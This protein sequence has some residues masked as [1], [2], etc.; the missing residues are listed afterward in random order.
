MSDAGL[1]RRTVSIVPRSKYLAAVALAALFLSLLELTDVVD[2]PF[3]AKFS[4][5][6][7]SGGVFSSGLLTSMLG[8]G[9]GGLFALMAME[10]ASL[11]IPSEVVLPW[12]GYL[13]FLGQMNLVLAVADST[14]ALLV[15]SLVAYFLALWLGRPVIYRILGR[16]GVSA[17]HLDDGERWIDSKGAWA[18]FV[19]RFIPGLRS[20]IS[21]PAGLLKMQIRSFA[22]LTFAGSLIWSTALIYVGYSAGSLWQS[23]LGSLYIFADQAALVI[24]AAV[25]VLYVLYYL[26][27]LGR[28][29]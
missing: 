7:A 10:G 25:S 22:I 5:V 3:E 27:P 17:S 23:A 29:K 1:P 21:I 18:V 26:G 20:V 16:M 19:S 8:I 6:V 11:P 2:L 12:A 24:V 15:G 14:M 13:V 9:Y 28:K 4:G